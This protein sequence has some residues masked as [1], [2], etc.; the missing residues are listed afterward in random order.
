MLLGHPSI[1]Q[2]LALLHGAWNYPYR[3]NTFCSSIFSNVSKRPIFPWPPELA[4]KQRENRAGQFL[5][6]QGTAAPPIAPPIAS[7]RACI[8]VL[9]PFVCYG[10]DLLFKIHPEVNHSSPLHHYHDG[11]SHHHSSLVL[12]QLTSH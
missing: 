12:L 2:A 8:T 11:L 6:T 7:S 10:S 3:T 9:S 5:E 4:L 1:M